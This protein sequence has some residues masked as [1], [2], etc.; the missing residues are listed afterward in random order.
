M[1]QK[2]QIQRLEDLPVALGVAVAHRR[3]RRALLQA[4][5]GQKSGA[6]TDA[7]GNLPEGMAL[8]QLPGII[9]TN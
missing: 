8:V 1:P 6:D 5:I 9:D 7:L 2:P 3:L 4:D